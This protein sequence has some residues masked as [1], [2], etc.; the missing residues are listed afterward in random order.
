MQTFLLITEIKKTILLILW[1]Y[2]NKAR[3]VY[4]AFHEENVFPYVR[5]L[6][7]NAGNV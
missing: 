3:W 4:I 1:Y 6:N 2:L 7:S 5:N